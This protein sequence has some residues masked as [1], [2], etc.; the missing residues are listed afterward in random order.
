MKKKGL[1]FIQP[2]TPYG[3]DIYVGVRM[4]VNEFTDKVVKKARLTEKSVKDFR[5]FDHEPYGRT[6][7]IPNEG[8]ILL[9]LCEFDKRNS[10]SYGTLSHEIAH[11]VQ[12]V[13]NDAGVRDNEASAYLC[14]WLTQK[15]FEKLKT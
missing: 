7:L 1:L 10:F 8:I 13:C 11:V 2:A 15:I 5:D 3:I 12:F 14:G 6:W 4:S 9:W